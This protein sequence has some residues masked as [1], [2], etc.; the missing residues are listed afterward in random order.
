MGLVAFGQHRIG[1]WM[2]DKTS[3]PELPPG[4]TPIEEGTPVP[5]GSTLV[6]IGADQAGVPVWLRLIHEPN[7][8][9]LLLPWEERLVV[10]LGSL[11]L[12]LDEAGG[13]HGRYRAEDE[14]VSAWPTAAGLLLIGRK[15]VHMV[16]KSGERR[17]SHALEAEGLHFLNAEDGAVTLAQMGAD[18]WREVRLDLQT[19]ALLSV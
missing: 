1:F 15:G 16:G 9:S 8:A 10:G 6:L 13:L 3:A 12:F 14:W 7:G 11:V 4:M 18:D 2:A 17:W 5:G 19:G